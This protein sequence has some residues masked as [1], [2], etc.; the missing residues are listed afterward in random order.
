MIWGR[1]G[2]QRRRLS[3]TV[4]RNCGV[5]SPIL[6][7]PMLNL[8]PRDVPSDPRCQVLIDLDHHEEYDAVNDNHAEKNTE[9]NPFW[10]G[11]SDLEHIFQYVFPR[12][13]WKIRWL[14]VEH[15]AVQIILVLPLIIS[16]FLYE[17]LIN[18]QTA[19]IKG[20]LRMRLDNLQDGYC[21]LRYLSSP[22]EPKSGNWCKTL[23]NAT[24]VLGCRWG[25]WSTP[26][27]A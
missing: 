15:Q 20:K 7:V 11:H 27:L 3:E 26:I 8:S 6:L 2:P 4:R 25:V 22:E 24:R 9:I 18:S 5:L 16:Q 13:F 10:S 1:I 14:V 19:R 23:G 21:I 12:D 17:H